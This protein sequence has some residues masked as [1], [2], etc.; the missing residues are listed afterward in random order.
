MNITCNKTYKATLYNEDDEEYDVEDYPTHI[1]QRHDCGYNFV[2]AIKGIN[3][4]DSDAVIANYE[5]DWV[6]YTDYDIVNDSRLIT[7]L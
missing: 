5:D 3:G 1:I 7:K 2:L 6:D 4:Y